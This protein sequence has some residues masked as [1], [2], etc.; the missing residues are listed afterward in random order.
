M[1]A[2][3]EDA[4]ADHRG[5]QSNALA[6]PFD[7]AISTG[8]GQSWPWQSG[9]K[10][11]SCARISPLS[12]P[13]RNMTFR[14]TGLHPTRLQW[15][16]NTYSKCLLSRA[17]LSSRTLITKGSHHRYLG[18]PFTSS[19]RPPRLSTPLMAGESSAEAIYL[20]VNVRRLKGNNSMETITVMILNKRTAD[21]QSVVVQ[22]KPCIMVRACIFPSRLS[23]LVAASRTIIG[24]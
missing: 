10:A 20:R 12:A 8:H 11:S 19:L 7:V 18:P 17:K 6:S 5:S 3:V 9:N 21:A 23:T 24:L 4:S 22:R 15:P 2:L 16:T 13:L 14:A 1:R